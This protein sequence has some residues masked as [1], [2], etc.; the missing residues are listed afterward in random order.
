MST[1]VIWIAFTAIYMES[2]VSATTR[3]LAIMSTTTPV[4]KLEST[5]AKGG[6]RGSELHPS[7]ES[8]HSTLDLTGPNNEALVLLEDKPVQCLIDTGSCVSTIGQ[9]YYQQQMTVPMH[10]VTDFLRVEVAN[11]ELPN[12]LGYVAVTLTMSNQSMDALFLIVPDTPYNQ[13]VPV[14]MG[15]NILKAWR[16]EQLSSN[17]AQVGELPGALQTAL[18]TLKCQEKQLN[19]SQGKV[20]IFRCAETIKIPKYTTCSVPGY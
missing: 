20:G 8:A 7:T 19:R 15:T 14:L 18:T 16:Q 5:S 13:Q 10:A 17:E 11:G 3:K 9:S 2:G 4:F 12:Y 1:D 6:T